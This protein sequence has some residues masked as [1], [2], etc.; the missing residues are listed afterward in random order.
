LGIHN[1]PLLLTS[2]HVISPEPLTEQGFPPI[3]HIKTLCA[4]A[5][6]ANQTF[7]I[8]SLPS[9][10]QAEGVPWQALR[11]NGEGRFATDVAIHGARCMAATVSQNVW[12][13][14]LQALKASVWSSHS[15]LWVVLG[16]NVCVQ[17][18]GSRFAAE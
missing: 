3:R 9:T 1:P 4:D 13:E 12:V 16:Q 11:A 18:S 7:V 15:N 2:S 8:L 5:R 10:G 14:P 6:H 17:D